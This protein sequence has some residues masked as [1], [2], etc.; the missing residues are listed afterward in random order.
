MLSLR[1]ISTAL[2]CLLFGMSGRGLWGGE[3]SLPHNRRLAQERCGRSGPRWALT[4]HR[5]KVSFHVCLPSRLFSKFT[6]KL[7]NLLKK[8]ATDALRTFTASAYFSSL[9]VRHSAR[10]FA[11][12]TAAEYWI[13]P[14][15]MGKNLVRMKAH[16]D[17]GAWNSLGGAAIPALCLLQEDVHRM[18]F[19]LLLW[20]AA[21]VLPWNKEVWSTRVK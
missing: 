21:V 1:V 7:S 14:L 17:G 16:W 20:P 18:G 9:I 8:N 15:W 12:H 2:A 19:G 5:V 13:A 4:L 10:V 3:L 11:L 6:P